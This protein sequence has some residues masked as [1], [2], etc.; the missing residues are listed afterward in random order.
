VP[1]MDQWA[2]EDVEAHMALLRHISELLE[3]NG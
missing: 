3:E 1:L 2:P